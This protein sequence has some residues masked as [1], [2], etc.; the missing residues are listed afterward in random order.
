MTIK[1]DKRSLGGR[2]AIVT[3]A[4]SGVGLATSVGLGALGATVVLAD[5]SPDRLEEAAIKMAEQNIRHKTVQCDVRLEPDVARLIAEA[6]NSFGR[7]DILCNNAG[8]PGPTRPVP[9][10]DV[11]DDDWNRVFDTNL[12]AT[13]YAMRHAVPALIKSRGAVI[14]TASICG[15]SMKGSVVYGASKAALI[16]LTKGYAMELAAKGVRVNCVC[17]GMVATRFGENLE[18]T[19]LKNGHDALVPMGRIAQPDEIAEAIIY[20]ASDRSAYATGSV[21]VVDGGFSMT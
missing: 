17:P 12:R 2:T 9:T 20:F 5:I 11:S 7:L 1:D 15:L 21:L 13:F 14:N 16:H 6:T 3:G 19:E 18:R 8:V 4:G 10:W